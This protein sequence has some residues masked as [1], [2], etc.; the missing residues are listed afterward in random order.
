MEGI[1]VN[2][3]NPDRFFRLLK[4]GCHGNQFWAKLAKWPSFSTLLF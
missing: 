2:V 4:A 1:C 3:V